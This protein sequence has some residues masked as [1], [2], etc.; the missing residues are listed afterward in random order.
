MTSLSVIVIFGAGTT[1]ARNNKKATQ[2]VVSKVLGA[3]I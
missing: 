2:S 3:V 1:A